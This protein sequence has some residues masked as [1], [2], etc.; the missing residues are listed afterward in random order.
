MQTKKILLKKSQIWVETAIYTLIGLT[1]IAVVL[2]ISMP[3]IER[4]KDRSV[5]SQTMNTLNSI[6]VKVEEAKESTGNIRVVDLRIGKGKIEIDPKTDEIRYIL[7][8]TRYAMNEPNQS[9]KEGDLMLETQIF[10]ERYNDIITINYSGIINLEYDR[11]NSLKTLQSGTGLHRLKIENL[12]YN[13]VTQ[14]STV[15]ISVIS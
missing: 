2:S 5:V 1:M 11:G 15:D 8:N 3:Q 12:E 9:F 4:M 10:G 13:P 7:Q 14:I 6:F